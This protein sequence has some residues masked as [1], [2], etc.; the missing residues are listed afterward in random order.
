MLFLAKVDAISICSPDD[1]HF[2]YIVKSLDHDKH[3]LV[4]KPM[5]ANLDEA[6][7][8]LSIVNQKSNRVVAVHHQ[9]RYVPAFNLAKE[10]LRQKR[11][12]DVFYLEANYWHDMRLRNTQFDNWRI[13]GKGQSVIFGAA[14][15]PMDLIMYLMEDTPFEHTTFLCKNAYK[16]YPLKYTASTTLMQFETGATAK[17]HTNNCVRYP[18]YNNLIILGEKASFIDGVVFENNKY[19]VNP[20]KDLMPI[21]GSNS[22]L[23]IQFFEKFVWK[24]FSKKRLIRH[25]PLSVYNHETACETIINDF[26]ESIVHKK[27]PLVSVRDAFNVIKLCE[28]A[29]KDGLSKLKILDATPG[30]PKETD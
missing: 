21:S 17:C 30:A 16:S 12:G 7:E 14:C 13:K 4:E 23:L 25:F 19:A 18:Q 2:E 24:Y 11:L 29:E 26:I 27:K 1:S 10:L 22:N 8:L 28:E 20:Y 6:N 5:V 15:H 9:M 3:V